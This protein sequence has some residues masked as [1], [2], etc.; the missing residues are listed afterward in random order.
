M[1][2]APVVVIGGGLVGLSCAWFLRRAGAEVVVLERGEPG[3][4]ASC[5]NAGA[6]CP[7]MT[8]PLPAPGMI[9]EALANL[10]RADAALH[11]APTYAPRMARF[12][13]RFAAAATADRFERGLAAFGPLAAGVTAAYDELAAAGIG[14][15]ARREGY[16]FVHATAGGA[17]AERA[18]I[19][20]MASMG[21]CDEPGDVVGGADLWALE[22]AL[23]PAAVA[24]FLLPGERWIDPSRFVDDLA[25][26]LVADGVDLRTGTE[27]TGVAAFEDGV[28]VSTT[29][30][31]V[32]GAV[33]V[34]AAGA[35]T[36]RVLAR[37]GVR[38]PILAGKGYSFEVRP[39]APVH[40]P[41]HLSAAHVMATPFDGRLRLAGTVE[42]DG[43]PDAF[44]PARIDAIV[45]AAE[46]FLDVDLTTRDAGWV[47]PRPMTPDGLPYL[48]RVPG[49]DRV[50]VAAGHNM[51]GLTLAPVTG[52]IVA[53]LVVDDDPGVDLAPFAVGR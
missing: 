29:R 18:A 43:M 48:G 23:G 24:G 30:D 44:H 16:L 7:S 5:G 2:T 39:R 37:L 31:R 13:R 32:D 45:R 12:L 4:G 3:G 26:S 17:V 42:F 53:G 8:E 21:V 25:A 49:H 34:V 14:T 33:A 38:L 11:V 28:E 1:S 50:V 51:L 15:H 40:R 27:V 46:G 36:P 10:G 20:R 47:G 52:R 9:R 35:W 22:P 41:I 6:I 19:A